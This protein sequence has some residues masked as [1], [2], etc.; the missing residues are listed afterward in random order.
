MAASLM[1]IPNP[2]ACMHAGGFARVYKAELDGNVIALKVLLPEWCC[3]TMQKCQ[4]YQQD[5][6]REGNFLRD[7]SHK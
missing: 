1:F 4:R 6:V 7:N 2:H 3:P 5:F